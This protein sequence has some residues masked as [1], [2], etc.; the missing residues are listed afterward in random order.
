MR[1]FILSILLLA[2][3]P[4][5]AQQGR[6]YLISPAGHATVEGNSNNVYPWGQTQSHYQQIHADLRSRQLVI[7]G[8]AWRRDGQFSTPAANT[9]DLELSVGDSD[10]TKATTTFASNCV[11]TPTVAVKRK[12]IVMPSWIWTISTPRLPGPFDFEIPFDTPWLFSGKQDFLW[13]VRLFSSPAARAIADAT[14]LVIPGNAAKSFALGKGCTLAGQT[15]PMTLEASLLVDSAWKMSLQWLCRHT[16]PSAASNVVL[17]GLSNPA[18]AIP[19]L[20]S[21]KLYTDALLSFAAPASNA[22]G[23]FTTTKVTAYS[24]AGL[25]GKSFYAQA[26]SRDPNQTPIPFAASNG[27]ATIVPPPGNGGPWLRI[28]NNSSATAL[29]G[30]MGMNYALVTKVIGI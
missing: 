24:W 21:Q 8:L 25:T 9:L 13:E 20:C 11:G 26:F 17:I 5:A 27:L 2:A 19:G 6:P 22:S 7:L 30:S 3:V 18:A 28:W 4:V 16:A 29:S 14:R 15:K 23:I 12:K 10:Y 1:A